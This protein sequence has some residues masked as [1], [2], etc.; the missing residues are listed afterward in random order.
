[1]CLP[2]HL[3][4][5]LAFL[6]RD[7]LTS[8]PHIH[9]TTFLRTFLLAG[10]VVIAVSSNPVAADS[11]RSRATVPVLT[12]ELIFPLHPQHNHAPGIVELPNGDLLA[13][14]YRGS[15]ERKADD[16]AVY[17]ARLKKGTKQWSEAFL[18]VD[19]PG[20]PDGNTALFIDARKRLWL[21][22]HLG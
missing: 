8:Y 5:T 10:G 11:T 20:F 13:S 15:G 14:W 6:E 17:G 12:A 18:M 2:L 16:V 3:D 21:P 4:F 7:P 1:M 19:T 9:A 22:G